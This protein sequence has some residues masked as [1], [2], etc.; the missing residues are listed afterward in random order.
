MRSALPLAVASLLVVE[1]ANGTAYTASAANVGFSSVAAVALALL[2]LAWHLRPS[3][4]AVPPRALLALPVLAGAIALTT[5]GLLRPGPL[6][7][8]GVAAVLGLVGFGAAAVVRPARARL[9]LVV[10]SALLTGIALR[11]F[12]LLVVPVHPR[13]ADMLPLVV[14][15]LRELSAGLAPYRMYHFPWDVPLTYLPLSWLAYGPA[16]AAGVDLRWTS[17][18]A[19]VAVLGA[20]LFAGRRRRDTTARDA[21]VTLWAAWFVGHATITYDGQAAAAVQWAAL[22]WVVALAIE[23][24]TATPVALGLALAT[25]VLAVPLV[26]TLAVAWALGRQHPGAARARRRRGLAAAAAIAAAVTAV[27]VVPF[28]VASPAGFAEG[29]VRWFGD[30]DGFPRGKWLE[31]RA[32]AS[33]PGFAGLLWTLGLEH[34]GKL[35]Q[36]IV[37]GAFAVR[38]AAR[39]RVRPVGRVVG[40]ELVAAML[41]F[42]VWNPVVWGYLWYAPLAMVLVVA[43]APARS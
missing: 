34:A 7:G 6:L 21:A 31:N 12:E 1:I 13:V 3:W 4:P 8:L 20:V 23:M 19:E 15:A 9:L 27:V 28:V 42:L 36:I 16:W 33:H 37:L 18:L 43:A 35:V 40:P 24:H 11:S 22:A 17:T 10:V 30:L 14:V 26:P 5:R 32:W 2:A 41:A 29:V 38:F 25:T 39:L